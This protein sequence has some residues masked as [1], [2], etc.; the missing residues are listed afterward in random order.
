MLCNLISLTAEC[1]VILMEVFGKVHGGF[2]EVEQDLQM[3]LA[4]ICVQI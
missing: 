4:L 3:V 1:R 2:D